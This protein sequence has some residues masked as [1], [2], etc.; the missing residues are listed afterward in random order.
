MSKINV[1]QGDAQ[2]PK[3]LVEKI[4]PEGQTLPVVVKVI[5]KARKGL[6]IPSTGLAEVIPP[7]TAT[8]VKIRS[9]DQAWLLVTDL[10]TF[11]ALGNNKAEDFGV[12]EVPVVQKGKKA[13]AT[14]TGGVAQ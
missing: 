10:A 7:N 14:E 9:Y 6:V 11:A 5:H 1:K 4:L 2:A 3:A 8:E 13:T 12:I